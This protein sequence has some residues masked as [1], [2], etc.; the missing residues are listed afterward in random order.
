MPDDKRGKHNAGNT[1]EEEHPVPAIAVAYRVVLTNEDQPNTHQSM[2]GK[3]D[4]DHDPLKNEETWQC[5]EVLDKPE[6]SLR[7][8]QSDAV[9]SDV[10]EQKDTKW[11]KSGE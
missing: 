10:E 6:I 8:E 11:K 4:E 5:I 7:A 9:C 3:W 2:E 1:L